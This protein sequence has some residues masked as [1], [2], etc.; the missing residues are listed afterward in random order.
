MEFF[1]STRKIIRPYHGRGV[2]SAPSENENQEYFRGVKAA[3]AWGWLNHLHVQN[4]M[5]IWEAKPPGTLWATP[6]LLRDSFT[7]HL[8]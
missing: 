5:E 3:G 6:G 7:L 8:K 1:K 4:V 2:D